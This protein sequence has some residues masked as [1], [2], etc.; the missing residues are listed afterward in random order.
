MVEHLASIA[1]ARRTGIWTD[2]DAI[3]SSEAV[4]AE[5][6]RRRGEG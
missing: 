5:A 3:R 6:I 1:E 2:E 4:R